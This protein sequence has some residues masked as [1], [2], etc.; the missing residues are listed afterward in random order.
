MRMLYYGRVSAIIAVEGLRRST[1]Q[2]Q[3]AMK[4]A[5]G[6]RGKGT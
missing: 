5:D 4:E 1:Q 3:L 2:G 6:D